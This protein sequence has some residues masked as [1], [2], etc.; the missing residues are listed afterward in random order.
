MV[1]WLGGAKAQGCILCDESHKAKHLAPEAAAAG[2]AEA[3]GVGG[4]GGAGGGRGGGRPK[5]VGSS[6]TAECVAALQERCPRARVVYCSATGAS[7][8]AHM[9]YMRRLGLYCGGSN[10]CHSLL[11][12]H[13]SPL[14]THY[15]L[16]ATHHTPLTTRHSPLTT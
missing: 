7:A 4:A 2:G 10:A 11:T 6:K 12:T 16:L 3:G 13:H 8:V 1:A 9:C 15:S 14:T 5:K